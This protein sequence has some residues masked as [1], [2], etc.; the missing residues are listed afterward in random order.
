MCHYDLKCRINCTSSQFLNGVNERISGLDLTMNPIIYNIPS[1]LADI[2]STRLDNWRF[3]NGNST[4]VFNLLLPRLCENRFKCKTRISGH[5]W[6]ENFFVHGRFCL[7]LAH[8]FFIFK[9]IN[10]QRSKRSNFTLW[11]ISTYRFF[12]PA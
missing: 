12:I 3:S 11:L 4:D 5:F 10:K 2:T 9:Q 8:V 7:H 1:W 6:I